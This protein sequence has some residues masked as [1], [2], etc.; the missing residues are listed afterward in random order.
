MQLTSLRVVQW[1]ELEG[2]WQALVREGFHAA[3][4]GIGEAYAGVVDVE[5]KVAEMS[6]YPDDLMVCAAWSG[7]QLVGLLVGRV[8][9][10][11]LV[12]YDLFV[13]LA[14]RR[15]GIGRKLVELAI[16]ESRISIVAA[17]VNRKNVASQALLEALDF[18]RTLSSDWF[19]LRLPRT[20]ESGSP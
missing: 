18:Q 6:A 17:E 9:E 11:R 5:E 10:D 20:D 19:V 1:H 12:L 14:F 16:R 4:L 15:R 3:Y 7:D 13:A 2:R 8:K